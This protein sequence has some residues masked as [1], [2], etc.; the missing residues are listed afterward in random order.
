MNRYFAIEYE[1]KNVYWFLYTVNSRVFTKIYWYTLSPSNKT[2][3]D[4]PT[5]W[6]AQHKVT[7]PPYHQL[8]TRCKIF[9][10]MLTL[11]H[12]AKNPPERG[13]SMYYRCV[14]PFV[15]ESDGQTGGTAGGLLGE[16]ALEGWLESRSVQRVTPGGLGWIHLKPSVLHAS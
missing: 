4:P 16:A 1:S 7:H 13:V 8:D 15:E 2:Q 5:L 3:D 6:T 10:F 11:T 12:Q 14:L 9:E